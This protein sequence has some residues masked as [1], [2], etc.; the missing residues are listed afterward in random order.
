MAPIEQVSP[1]LERIAPWLNADSQDDR[2]GSQTPS[3][4][5]RRRETV[6]S[7]GPLT[8]FANDTGMAP[9]EDGAAWVQVTWHGDSG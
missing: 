8:A 5:S 4:G 9:L 1:E 2:W 3:A 7:L 6:S